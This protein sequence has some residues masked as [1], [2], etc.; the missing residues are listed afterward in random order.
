MILWRLRGYSD[1]EG[2]WEGGE[3]ECAIE[4]SEDG[5]RL[6]VTHN[7]EIQSDQYHARI[8]NARGK[9]DILRADLLKK[10]WSESE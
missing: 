5:Y 2:E 1:P 9:A 10:G 8:E 4:M 3:V 6:T 7:G